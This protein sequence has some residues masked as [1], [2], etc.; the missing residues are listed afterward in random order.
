MPKYN[1]SCSSCDREWS[2]WN[3]MG[4]DAV[5]CPHCFSKNIK[6][7]PSSFTVVKIKQGSNKTAKENVVEH[8]EENKS[9]LK[10]IKEQSSEEM[11]INND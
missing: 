5:E 7:L 2:Q 9:I 6:K 1:Y 8:I 3:S 4:V 11:V 10:K